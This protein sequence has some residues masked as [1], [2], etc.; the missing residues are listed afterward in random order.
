MSESLGFDHIKQLFRLSSI[1]AAADLSLKVA[2]FL[3]L[4]IYTLFLSPEQYGIIGL[5]A[6]ITSGLSH[7]FSVGLRAAAFNFY[8]RYE[9]RERNQFYTELFLFI[10]VVSVVVLVAA[11]YLGPPVFAFILGEDLYDP[12]LRIAIAAAAVMATFHMIPKERLKA[13]KSA[14]WYAVLSA[15]RGLANHALSVF[16]VAVLSLGAVGYLLGNLASAILVGFVGFAFIAHWFVAPSS[17]TKL[18]TALAYSLPMFPHFYSH[19]LISMADRALL[20]QYLT[21][22]VVGI[23]TVGYSIA[24][25]LQTLF[26]AINNAVMPETARAHASSEA[27]SRLPRLLTYYVL[28]T[29]FLTVGFS[30]FAPVVIRLVFPSE[31]VRSIVVLPWLALGFFA[32]SL[33]YLP[34]NLLTQKERDT[35]AI[36]FA[37]GFAALLNIVLNIVLIPRIGIVGAALSTTAAYAGL[38]AVIYAISQRVN[39]FP[40]ETRRLWTVI[41]ATVVIVSGGAFLSQTSLI[42][43]WALRASLVVAFIAAVSMSGFWYDDEKRDIKKYI[44]SMISRIRP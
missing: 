27:A 29:G 1:Y 41:I 23:Y 24:I 12:Y 34:M 21:L 36:P 38:G 10:F 44:R 2:G 30:T 16:A 25:A 39:R 15:G 20:S 22:S 26:S 19:F 31:Y 40:Y 5:A 7:F 18:G 13:A 11:E 32:M 28:I 3:L 9:G 8:H 37:T 14:K 43:E 35:R 6:L 33:Y 17:N 4:P 42:V